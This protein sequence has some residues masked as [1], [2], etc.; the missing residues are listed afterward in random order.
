MFKPDFSNWKCKL[1]II[2]ELVN[3]TIVH[4]IRSLSLELTVVVWVKKLH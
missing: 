3:F 1:P 2:S 4:I